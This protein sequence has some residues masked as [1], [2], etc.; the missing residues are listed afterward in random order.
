MLAGAY[1][2]AQNLKPS[3]GIGALPGDNDTIC[4]IPLYTG[5]YYTSGYQ[6]GDTVPDFTL[7]DMNGQPWNLATELGKGKP[8]LLVAG[9][10]TCPVFRNQMATINNIYNNLSSLVT[11]VIVNVVEAHPTDPSPYSGTVWITSANQS[12]G[13]LH[14]QPT[15][16]GER[17]AIV[18]TML[19][20]MTI[21]APILIDGPCNNWWLNYGPAPNNSYLIDTTGIIFSKHGWFHKAPDDIYCDIDSMLNTTTGYCNTAG[22][23]GSFTYS[24]DNDTIDYG[25]PTATLEV[26]GTITNLSSTNNVS[27]HIRKLQKNYPITWGTALC[28]VVCHSPSEDTTTVI[29][30]P[31]GTQ[32]FIFYF[33]TDSIPAAGHCRIGFRNNN[34]PSNQFAFNHWGRTDSVLASSYYMAS[35]NV[36]VYPN[37]AENML[38][39]DGLEKS[40]YYEFQLRDMSGR[41]VL[42]DYIDKSGVI[43]LN[44]MAIE[45]GIY[46]YTLRDNGTQ[47]VQGKLIL[48]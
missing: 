5:S 8:I 9:S 17:K 47:L 21:N 29:I 26:H 24:F 6:D 1:L 32:K 42:K 46:L 25:W 37:P 23:G 27:V 22:N 43:R 28:A 44:R 11:V 10:Y 13:I 35:E 40:V 34:L 20:A 15:T 3:I 36:Q 19:N 12:A 33:Y 16:Y 4:T 7:Y 18:D 38:K 48:K 31:S 2:S 41:V 30:P 45:D 14:P 39:I